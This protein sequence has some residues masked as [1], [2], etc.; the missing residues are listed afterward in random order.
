MCTSLT[1]QLENGSNALARTMDFSFVLDP[2][3]Y[4]IP[5]NYMWSSQVDG[6]QYKTKYAFTGLARKLEENIVLADG[7]NE[8]GL[9]CAVLYFPGYAVYAD[10]AQA[11]RMNLAPHE[12][13]FSL[14]ANCKDTEDVKD[15]VKHLNIVSSPVSLLGIVPPFHWIV[16]DKKNNTIV[17]EPLA[18]GISIVDN[19]VGVMSNSPDFNWHLT[20]VRSYIGLRPYQ[21]KSVEVDGVTFSPFGQASGTVG[22]PGDY[23]P[24][25]RFLRVLFGKTTINR[26]KTEAEAVTAIFHLLNSVNIPKGS[27]VK[28]D[29][30]VDYT[31]HSSCMFCESCTYYFKTYDNSQIS[32]VALLSEDLDAKEPKMWIIPKEQQINNINVRI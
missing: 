6:T 11:N 1:Y 20:N 8:R 4:L 19:R 9:A 10:K 13:L 7:I 22:L 18:D 28:D 30:S 17:I 14:L 2:D 12:V 29:S 25:S 15:I 27:V 31:Q 21:N 26:V 32:K 23:T 5:R 16:T 3:M 24:P